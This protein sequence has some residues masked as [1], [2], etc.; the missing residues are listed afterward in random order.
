MSTL[1]SCRLPGRIRT[2][3]GSVTS[4]KS[5]ASSGLSVS[6]LQT[7][8]TLAQA[9]QRTS[10]S[11]DE[12]IK[13]EAARRQTESSREVKIML[14]GQAESGKST[15]QKQFQLYHASH[16][17]DVERP[18]WRIVVYA[19]LIKAVRTILEELDYEFS[20]SL[21]EYPFPSEGSGPT[22]VGAQNEILELRRNLLPLISLEGSLSSELSGGA[23]FLGT[24]RG[25]SF[26]RRPGLF[27]RESSRPVADLR[28]SSGAVV[29]T[30]RA[31][32][33]LASTVHVI[34]ALWRHR[35]V[36]AMLRL[37]K[38]KL[39]ESGLFFLEQVRRIAEP[40]YIPSTDDVLHVRLPTVGVIEHSLKVNTVGG[41]YIWRI[42][43]VGGTR[44]QR[45][46]WC[47]YFDD[48][49]ALIFLVP[50]SAFDQ[51]LDEDPL[52]NR[53]HDS[54]QLLMSIWTNELLKNAQLVLLL[55]KIDILRKKLEAGV[56]VRQYIPSYGNRP[57]NFSTAAEYFR[58]HFLAAHKK[59]DSFQRRLY[60]HLTTMLDVQAT[61]V[62][63][64]SV[65]DLIM[66]KHIAQTGLA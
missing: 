22:D 30:N 3:F 23:S 38:L 61:Q 51:Y 19:N 18:S 46:A 39:D 24:R 29:A 59:K 4:R 37:R 47:S 31:A 44:S 15:L 27:T 56:Q 64:T 34:E 49:N 60:V 36:D 7:S 53:I 14:L 1:I 52:T 32:Q 11:I 13:N 17:L 55:N 50:I 16:T 42:Y 48:V 5:S 62:I 21:A 12:D 25:T 33:V 58:S 9:A 10:D 66:R 57:N 63:I 54:L 65:G 41:S 20:S 35:S 40:D 2:S 6:Q 8:P 28:E 45:P 43:D 26:P